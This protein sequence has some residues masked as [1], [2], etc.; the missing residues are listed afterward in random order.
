[1]PENIDWKFIANEEGEKVLIGYVPLP[2][3]SKSGVTIASGFDLGQHNE[4]DLKGLKLSA[5]LTKKLKP[6]LLLKKQDAVDFLKKNPLTITKEEADEID[7]A[8]KKKLVP[9]L[10]TRYLNSSYNKTNTI[11]D[12]LPGQAQTV[13]AS[14][15]FQYGDLNST[16]N[17]FWQAVSTQDWKEAVKILRGYT[18]YRPRRGREADLLDQLVKHD[19]KK[20][21]VLSSIGAWTAVLLFFILFGGLSLNIPAQTKIF[22]A[23]LA[24]AYKNYDRSITEKKTPMLFES[25]KKVSN[26]AEY[27]T[28]KKTSSV[29][30]DFANMLYASE[31]LVCDALEI[32]K[33]ADASK[34]A[35]GK[36][37][38]MNYGREIYNRLN[39]GNLPSSLVEGVSE[40]PVFLKN[41]LTASRP[42]ITKYRIESETPQWF[43]AVE[44]VA[45]VDFDHN[46]KKDLILQV[47]DEAR[48]GNYRSYTTWLVLNAEKT[49]VLK[50]EM[51]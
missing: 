35:A 27:T 28:E 47:I 50:A 17:T 12:D 2:G 37:S 5:D 26:C 29:K 24:K 8:L 51:R 6:Y 16:R 20:A 22:D 30:S 46:G 15:S 41:K 14:L 49:G 31:Y 42:K 11:F 10:K 1:M 18:D 13:I 43:F 48:Q 7:L 36:T 38:P 21:Q 9:Q 34:K 32:L 19:E 25:G 3:K 4:Y 40:K 45:E 33:E 44:T 39:I 23:E